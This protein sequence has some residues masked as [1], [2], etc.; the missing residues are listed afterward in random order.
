MSVLDFLTDG[1][2]MSAIQA[3]S[4]LSDA[5]VKTLFVTGINKLAE[6]SKMSKAQKVRLLGLLQAAAEEAVSG[7]KEPEAEPVE[8]KA[9]CPHCAVE[10]Y[11]RMGKVVEAGVYAPYVLCPINGKKY[12]V[13]TRGEAP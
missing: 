10:H 3:L 9:K 1:I 13:N 12:R 8:G 5:E 6:K 7:P 11:V 4:A 2:R